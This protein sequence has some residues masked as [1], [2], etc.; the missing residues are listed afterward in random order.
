MTALEPSSPDN[1]RQE[2]GLRL[3]HGEAPTQ[4]EALPS[5]RP[6]SRA[7]RITDLL[8][9]ATQ[10]AGWLTPPNGP[11]IWLALIGLAAWAMLYLLPSGE[12]MPGHTTATA[13]LPIPPPGVVRA[14]STVPSISVAIARL[15]PVPAPPASI[16]QTGQEPTEHKTGKSQT[17]HGSP[18]RKRAHAA[19]VHLRAPAY[20]EPCRYQCDWTG[21]IA[22]HGGGY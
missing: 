2:P 12:P 19:F 20:S 13:S 8:A 11:V 10:R 15:D 3:W 17:W 16:A 22:W 7:Q 5:I 6:S 9:S 1:E 4:S 18:H 21:S 14:A